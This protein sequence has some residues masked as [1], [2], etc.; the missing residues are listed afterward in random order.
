MESSSKTEPTLPILAVTPVSNWNDYKQALIAMV[1]MNP[2]VYGVDLVRSLLNGAESLPSRPAP[3]PFVARPREPAPSDVMAHEAWEIALERHLFDQAQARSQHDIKEKQYSERLAQYYSGRSALFG[4]QRSHLA[5]AT[6]ARIVSSAS[7]GPALDEQDGL[8]LFLLSEQLCGPTA[9]LHKPADI[10]AEINR[11]EQI[12][13][14]P[15]EVAEDFAQRFR[16]QLKVVLSVHPDWDHFLQVRLYLASTDTR[17][18]SAINQRISF[19]AGYPASF[20]KAAEFLIEWEKSSSGISGLFKPQKG[21]D[22]AHLAKEDKAEPRAPLYGPC[23][24]CKKKHLPYDHTPSDR[25]CPLRRSSGSGSG[26]AP[27][28]ASGSASDGKKKSSGKKKKPKKSQASVA[29]T[30]VPDVIMMCHAYAE[31]D[32]INCFGI[33]ADYASL[34]LIRFESEDDFVSVSNEV[35][36]AYVSLALEDDDTDSLPELVD[37]DSETDDFTELDDSS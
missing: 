10:T 14:K 8:E 17:F 6:E 34:M 25:Y 22:V 7:Y 3:L 11:L 1:Q 37:S 2:R 23:E 27:V 12:R 20:E 21:T 15:R 33:P 28:T 5:P 4:L 36:S 32:Y 19:G 18:H 24:K 35:S 9:A 30:S 31:D 16:K 29:T 26:S 13:Q